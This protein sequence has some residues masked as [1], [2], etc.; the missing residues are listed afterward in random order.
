MED[1][2]IFEGG[3]KEWESRQ[4]VEGIKNLRAISAF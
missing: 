3:V 4:N 2:E 1:N